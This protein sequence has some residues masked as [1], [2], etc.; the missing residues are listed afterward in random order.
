MPPG[1]SH[2]E[3]AHPRGK[4]VSIKIKNWQKHQHFKDRR[5]PW[6]KLYRELLDDPD[7]HDLNPDDAKLLVG[8]WLVA[9]EDP[10]MQGGLPDTKKLAFRL[11]TTEKHLIHALTRLSNWLE[12]DDI[13]AISERYQVDAPETETETERENRDR[14]ISRGRDRT[15]SASDEASVL[16]FNQFWQ[17]YPKKTGKQA[18]LKAWCRLKDH[19]H[20]LDACLVALGWQSGCDQWRKE[21]GQFIPNPA[22][23]LTQGR[24]EDLPTNVSPL[25]ARKVS[26]G[27][28][29]TE[30]LNS[31]GQTKQRKENDITA[32]A[33][34]LD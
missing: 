32:I 8:M 15:L 27:D 21:G 12:Q 6:V 22:T 17:A 33:V 31:I 10:N 23:Y 14:D 26:A 29:F 5:P 11:R 2:T 20:I 19:Q 7:W 25:P 9:S 18:A 34:R 30:A 13:K 28:R 24:W 16:L 4:I 3:A 1:N